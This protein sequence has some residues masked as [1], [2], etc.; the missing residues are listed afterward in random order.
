MEGGW[1]DGSPY[2]VVYSGCRVMLVAFE[3]DVELKEKDD[4]SLG[5]DEWL[6]IEFLSV[7]KYNR[8]RP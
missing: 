4:R 2:G 3:F 5:M 1:A 6:G 8:L 7:I